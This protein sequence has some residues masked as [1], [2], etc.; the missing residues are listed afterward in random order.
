MS[1]EI[2]FVRV[3][4]RIIN[5]NL[6]TNAVFCP[7]SDATAATL[8]VHFSGESVMVLAGDEAEG[9]WQILNTFYYDGLAPE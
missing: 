4:D 3:G 8:A 6:I 2:R 9:L 7:A 5:P 1:N